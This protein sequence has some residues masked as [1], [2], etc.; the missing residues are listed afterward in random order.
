MREEYEKL[1]KIF[2]NTNQEFKKSLDSFKKIYTDTL[3]QYKVSFIIL[4]I[5]VML[6]IKQFLI[7]LMPHHF[8]IILILLKVLD[9]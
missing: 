6:I 2:Q 3:N 1:F 5:N 7:V 8:V 9:L 4:M